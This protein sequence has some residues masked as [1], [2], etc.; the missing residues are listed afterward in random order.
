MSATARVYIGL[1]GVAFFW[2]TSWAASKIG[3]QEFSPLH[4]TIVRFIVA[5]L[6]LQKNIWII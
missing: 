1:F 3:L 4:L 2:G 6:K 5:S